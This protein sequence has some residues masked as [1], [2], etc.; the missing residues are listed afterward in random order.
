M[1]W[2]R[3][4]AT[5]AVEDPYTSLPQAKSRR[6]SEPPAAVGLQSG[7]DSRQHRA[8]LKS[9]P[10][11][12]WDKEG[13]RGRQRQ[14]DDRR[15]CLSPR[16]GRQRSCSAGENM[17]SHRRASRFEPP[18]TG[19]G[20]D[21][22]EAEEEEEGERSVRLQGVPV[23]LG[24]GMGR[25]SPSAGH[26]TLQSPYPQRHLRHHETQ[27][28]HPGMGIGDGKV[29]EGGKQIAGRQ[30]T[31]AGFGIG[32][33]R[34][35]SAGENKRPSSHPQR[36]QSRSDMNC[37]A[38]GV[39]NGEEG[40][41]I[42]SQGTGMGRQRSQSMG[43]G[44]YR[45]SNTPT[46][47]L[48]RT[49]P[50]ALVEKYSR[51]NDPSSPYAHLRHPSTTVGSQSRVSLSLGQTRPLRHDQSPFQSQAHPHPMPRSILRTH[52]YASDR[53]SSSANVPNPG[54]SHSSLSPANCRAPPPAIHRTPLS[55][56]HHV[57]T[58]QRKLP[59]SV[60]R[61]T[62]HASPLP[63]SHSLSPTPQRHAPERAYEQSPYSLTSGYV[64]QVRSDTLLDVN[65]N[66]MVGGT[67]HSQLSPL[68]VTPNN[69]DMPNNLSPD[70][71]VKTKTAASS[72]GIC[73]APDEREAQPSLPNP[74]PFLGEERSDDSE[75]DSGI[76]CFR[77]QLCTIDVLPY[78]FRSLVNALGSA[79]R[80]GA[81]Q[82][83]ER[84]FVQHAF[85][86][87]SLP[88]CESDSEPSKH[89]HTASPIACQSCRTVWCSIESEWI[90]G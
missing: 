77:D 33:R 38:I 82:L 4:P 79:I 72:H 37:E 1:F 74:H 43:E 48:A 49:R 16:M 46:S 57:T 70:A 47:P 42:H 25:R 89:E 21:K 56:T 19:T 15:V 9:N 36:R 35:R 8:P 84:P 62:G 75:N 3:T 71:Q 32:R 39:R 61:P 10:P 65:E 29:E 22:E 53:D 41:N 52:S 50:L 40:R 26:K 11:V 30:G 81:V 73:N 55:R 66:R 5:A 59:A 63:P 27:F 18:F 67:R 83:A 69:G 34:S 31:S 7:D 85:K 2:N 58:I 90:W 20:E 12:N 76:S 60:R 24:I 28:G 51:R 80:Y 86:P 23:E 78:V 14:E 54:T 88:K 44:L 64:G 45:N 13:E 68:Q 87:G 6:R 17:N